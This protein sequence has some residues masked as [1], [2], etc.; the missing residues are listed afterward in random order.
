MMLDE[1]AGACAGHRFSAS[2][3]EARPARPAHAATSMPPPRSRPSLLLALGIM[4]W[5]LWSPRQRD[6]QLLPIA[7][8]KQ[9]KAA[10]DSVKPIKD[11]ES[12]DAFA[13]GDMTWAQ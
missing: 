2:P 1:A 8:I 10:K 11:A 7:R 6:Q 13:A 9:E 5:R 3:Q 12:L 4:Q